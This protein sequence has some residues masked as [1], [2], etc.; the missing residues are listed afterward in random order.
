M[1]RTSTKL[2]TFYL[3]HVGGPWPYMN[4][5]LRPRFAKL[6]S[7][8]KTLPQ[9]VSVKP[10]AILVIS[11]HWEERDFAVMASPAPPMVYDF[12]VSRISIPRKVSRRGLTGTC[13]KNR[14]SAPR[15]RVAH[16]LGPCPWI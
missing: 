11:G 10:K 4:G 3:S 16:T 7:S 1:N 14:E 13:A 2:P 5:D 9:Q 12:G 8:L 6:E 15:R